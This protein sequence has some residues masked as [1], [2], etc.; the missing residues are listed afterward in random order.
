MSSLSARLAALLLLGF[1]APR[2]T[3]AQTREPLTGNTTAAATAPDW[4]NTSWLNTPNDRPLTREGLKG[5][6]I[7]LNFWTF[8]CWNCTNTLPALVELDQRYRDRGL[9][10][11]GIHSP[12][13]PHSG[14]HDKVNVAA[15]LRKYH[16]EYP[17]AQDNDLATWNL[18]DIEAWPSFV[19]ID[20]KGRI[21]Y[22]GAG[23][24]HPGDQWY[25]E[26]DGRIAALVA[27]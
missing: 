11:I 2:P 3:A 7:L 27:E 18:Y 16:I 14:E 24:F 4:R 19:L 22:R 1:A 15:A 23:E 13:F 26:W 21:R 8:G 20:R 6:V 12:E 17:V 5:R 9:T 25:R 10:I